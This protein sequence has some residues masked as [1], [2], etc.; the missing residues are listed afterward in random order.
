VTEGYF[1]IARGAR[2]AVARLAADG[3]AEV[4]TYDVTLYYPNLELEV[5]RT[6]GVDRTIVF[7]DRKEARQL[8]RVI[9]AITDKYAECDACGTGG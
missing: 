3:S 9:L 2:G 1:K 6:G 4:G 7:L 5:K 8:A